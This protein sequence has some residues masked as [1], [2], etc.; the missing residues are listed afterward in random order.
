VNR[1]ETGITGQDGGRERLGAYLAS[2]GEQRGW[3]EKLH[4]YI[5]RTAAPPRQAARTGPPRG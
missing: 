1:L 4:P 2:T 5:V 3:E